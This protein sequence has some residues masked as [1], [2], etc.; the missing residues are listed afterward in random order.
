MGFR[1]YV[2]DILKSVAEAWGVQ[3]NYEY[4]ELI[5]P[6]GNESMSGDEVA[7]EVIEKLGLEVETNGF[8]GTESDVVA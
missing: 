8:N 6:T 1:H 2:S 5:K 7:L 3:V 4:R